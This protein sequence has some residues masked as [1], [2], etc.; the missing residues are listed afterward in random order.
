VRAM[1]QAAAIDPKDESPLVVAQRVIND[2]ALVPG[3]KEQLATANARIATLTPDAEC[4]K[5]YRQHLID[6]TCEAAVAANAGR[7]GNEF[8]VDGMRAGLNALADLNAIKAQRDYWAAR[9][10]EHLGQGRVTQD[11]TRGEERRT[12]A[13]PNS[14]FAV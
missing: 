3:L 5:V 12:P 10:A 7:G 13:S 11:D 14:A 6:E 1:L 9:A 2:A 8:P 4:G